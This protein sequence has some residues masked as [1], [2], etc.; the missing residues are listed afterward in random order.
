M[1]GYDRYAYVNNSPV[2]YTDP[3]GHYNECSV[4]L[5]G[6]VKSKTPPGLNSRKADDE[7]V[8]G[9]KD[10]NSNS[11]PNCTL[12]IYCPSYVT[13]SGGID[14]PG[15]I[16]IGGLLVSLVNPEAGLPIV[17]V[18]AYTEKAALGN[19]YA[20]VLKLTSLGGSITLD[21]YGN[22]YISFNISVGRTIT[23]FAGFDIYTGHIITSD[24]LFASEETTKGFLETPNMFSPAF[25]SNTLFAPVWTAVTPIP[26]GATF[27]PS[28]E[29]HWA[30]NGTL[31]GTSLVSGTVS[32]TG[33][34]SV[35]DIW[36]D[37]SKI[38]GK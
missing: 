14:V 8:S 4:A 30:K 22:V 36:P 18:G 3:S 6:C 33:Q 1:Q 28:S 23:P 31:I 26:G 37:P 2:R 38:W 12:W 35:L 20:A 15:W 21:A 32:W 25:S 16:M 29:P 13:A 27:S 11:S 34:I 5:E 9:G 10:G 19:P 24:E 7:V 17:I